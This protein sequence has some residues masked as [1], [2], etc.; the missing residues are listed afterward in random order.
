MNVADIV[1]QTLRPLSERGSGEIR[2]PSGVNVHKAERAVS[3]LLGG[4]FVANGIKRRS[5]G[6]T[7]AALAGG[8]LLRRGV[9]RWWR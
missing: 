4:L 1:K 7:V 2:G 3:M 9:H 5:V 8:E 6:G